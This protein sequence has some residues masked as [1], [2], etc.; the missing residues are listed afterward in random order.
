MALISAFVARPMAA[1]PKSQI[2][3]TVAFGP[4]HDHLPRRQLVSVLQPLETSM[5]GS[6]TSRKRHPPPVHMHLHAERHPPTLPNTKLFHFGNCQFP[7][8]THKPCKPPPN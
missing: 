4:S 3:W 1:T 2:G 8:R 7:N 5:I 6:P